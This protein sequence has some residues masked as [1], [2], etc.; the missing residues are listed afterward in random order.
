MHQF[1]KRWD[2][3]CSADLLF[4][5]SVILICSISTFAQGR[6][7]VSLR[8]ES[9]VENDNLNLASVSKITGDITKVERLKNIKLGYSPN[10]GMTREIGR[11]QVALA[12][13][14]AGFAGS[15]VDLDAP[16]KILVRRAGQPVSEELIRAAIESVVLTRFASEQVSA[17]IVGLE[18]SASILVPIGK[19]DVRVSSLNARDPFSKFAVPVEI[20]VD[21]KVVKRI[22]ATLAI[23]AFA[24]VLVASKAILPN[25]KIAVSDVRLERI[26]LERPL[27]NY[28]TD[29]A[30]LPGMT[31][32]R[33]VEIGSP[34][35]TDLL[36]STNVIKYG[37]LVKVEAGTGNLKFSIRGEARSAG[38]IGDHI[39]VKNSQSGVLIQAVVIDEGVVRLIL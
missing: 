39:S 30:K 11:E 31:A 10:V 38:K 17:R 27:S 16:E 18:L 22:T 9:T 4:T 36:I 34:I 35:T 3:I 29:C 33:S 5:A 2:G 19:L 21:S 7:N 8:A 6:V 20:S 28:L 24:G 1:F 12:I 23:E 14:A 15:E 26:K 13:S 32:T 37:D 25:A